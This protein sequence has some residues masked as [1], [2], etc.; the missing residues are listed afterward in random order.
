MICPRCKTSKDLYLSR[1]GNQNLSAV[2]KLWC[3]AVRCHRCS[4]LFH[5]AKLL[6]GGLT[7]AR[8]HHHHRHRECKAA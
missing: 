4:T 3:V 2:Q 6:A 8:G 5:V 7:E 1:S